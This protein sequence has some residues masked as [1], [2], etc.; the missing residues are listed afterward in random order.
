MSKKRGIRNSFQNASDAPFFRKLPHNLK[1]RD[2]GCILNLARLWIFTRRTSHFPW[3]SWCF[4]S[5]ICS[6]AMPTA[7]SSMRF[8]TFSSAALS[9][10]PPPGG[11][12]RKLRHREREQRPANLFPAAKGNRTRISGTAEVLPQPP[13]IDRSR[14]RERE[15]KS[16]Y[17][18]LTGA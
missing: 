16:S 5:K 8:W 15:E 4:G 6:R 7:L 9:P 14:V 13:G 1:K 17:E 10:G 18:L 2:I 11:F 12:P 3:T